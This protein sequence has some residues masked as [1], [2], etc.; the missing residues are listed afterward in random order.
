MT[1]RNVSRPRIRPYITAGKLALLL[2]K[3]HPNDRIFADAACMPVKRE[4]Q[5][6]GYID[7]GWE[8]LVLSTKETE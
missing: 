8:R 1:N 4:G 2:A 5:E 7:F 6:I 3:L